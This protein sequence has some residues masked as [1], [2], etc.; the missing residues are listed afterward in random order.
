MEYT[1][2]KLSDG[3]YVEILTCTCLEAFS[4]PHVRSTCRIRIIEDRRLFM[5]AVSFL[6][7]LI[8]R[9]LAHQCYRSSETQKS[10]CEL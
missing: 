6:K 8:L 10:D 1:A 2:L 9:S 7:E 4:R 3:K 5:S